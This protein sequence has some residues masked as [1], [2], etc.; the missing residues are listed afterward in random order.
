MYMPPEIM[1]NTGSYDFKVDVWSSG[2]VAY[3]LITGKPPF[4]GATKQQL[5][6]SILNDEPNYLLSQFLEVSKECTD[7]LQ[8][9]LVKDP[10]K[11]FSAQQALDHPWLK[12]VEEIL[13]S[14]D[15]LGKD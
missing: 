6:D 12:D 5:S 10:K 13:W 9:V 1:K 11:R 2:V 14:D 3:I 8:N 15:S 7:F 4:Y